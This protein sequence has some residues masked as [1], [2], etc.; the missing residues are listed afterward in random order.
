MSRLGMDSAYSAAV[1]WSPFIMGSPL[2][3]RRRSRDG[4][5]LPLPLSFPPMAWSE[6]STMAR[7][8]KDRSY[9]YLNGGRKEGE[10]RVSTHILEAPNAHPAMPG[11]A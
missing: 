11:N 9:T 2:S 7:W 5:L 3:P 6:M 10:K 8:K 1:S 4:T